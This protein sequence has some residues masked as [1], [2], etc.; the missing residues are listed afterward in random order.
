MKKIT[1][2]LCLFSFMA[3]FLA[4]SKEKK[5][6]SYRNIIVPPR[7]EV[8]PDTVIHKSK[9]FDVEDTVKWVGNVYKVHLH[10][11][12]ND[13]LSYVKMD[14]GVMYRDNLIKMTIEREDSSVF[15]NRVFR[16]SMFENVISKQ[17]IDQ[18]VLLGMALEK[19]KT[20]KDNLYFFG[21]VGNPDELTDDFMVF[22][23][24]VSRMGDVSI[25]KLDLDE[26]KSGEKEKNESNTGN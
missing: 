21:K 15:F 8:I 25:H 16:K 26:D 1:F 23:I 2:F 18:N 4:C 20:D 12:S 7:K 11:Y 13:S 24:V 22:E 6:N 10:K 17:Y 14:N 5:S 3:V 9:G 19:E